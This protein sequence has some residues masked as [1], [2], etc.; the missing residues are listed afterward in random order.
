MIDVDHFKQLNDTYGHLAGDQAL[1]AIAARLRDNLREN[2]IIG[3]FGGEEFVVLLP[4]TGLEQALHVA[5]R[6]RAAIGA[7]P[8][9][10]D[11]GEVSVSVSIGVASCESARQPLSVEQ[12][13]KRADDALYVAKRRGRNQIKVA[14]LH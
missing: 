8:V 10:T 11:E 12:L 2:D 6:L 13:L 3:R 4:E 7:Q 5:E 9:P 1:R 14:P